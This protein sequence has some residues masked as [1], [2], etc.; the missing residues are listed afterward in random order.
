MAPLL[1]NHAGLVVTDL[2]AIAA[3]YRRWFGFEVAGSFTFDDD[4]WMNR[5]AGAP[6][7]RGRAIHLRGANAYLELFTFDEPRMLQ[8]AAEPWARGL[9]HLGFE[10]DDL[11]GTHAR[12]ASAG[13]R[14]LSDPQDPADGSLTVYGRDPEDNLF[15]LMQLG[16][17]SAAFSLDAIGQELS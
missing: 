16:G 8:S 1:L 14:F 9:T 4:P 7:A 17:E 12:M 2:E 6:I 13:V 11:E 15:E 5:I 10:V 3:F